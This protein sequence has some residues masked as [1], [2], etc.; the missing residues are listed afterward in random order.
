MGTVAQDNPHTQHAGLHHRFVSRLS[1]YGLVRWVL[2]NLAIP[3]ARTLSSP[4]IGF[5]LASGLKYCLFSGSWSL[6]A[7]REAQ[8]LFTTSGLESCSPFLAPTRSASSVLR[9]KGLVSPDPCKEKLLPTCLCSDRL[10][11]EDFFS[12]GNGEIFDNK[13]CQWLKRADYMNLGPTLGI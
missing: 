1:V 7:L 11:G 13:H 10:F 3:K 2:R 5:I 9:A 8:I 12:S 6:W 4:K